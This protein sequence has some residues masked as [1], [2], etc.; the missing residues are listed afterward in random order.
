MAPAPNPGHIQ[1]IAQIAKEQARS[2]V[3]KDFLPSAPLVVNATGTENLFLIPV[4]SV[5]DM[6][7]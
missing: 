1:H 5:E 2:L 3:L 4:K 7:G 6:E